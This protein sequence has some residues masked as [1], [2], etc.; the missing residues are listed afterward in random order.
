MIAIN[1]K[2]NM[3]PNWSVVVTII[4]AFLAAGVFQV[5]TNASHAERLRNLENLSVERSARLLRIEQ[6]LDKA[7]EML[8]MRVSDG[9]KK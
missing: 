1:T 2:R 9:A 4:L 3:T 5:T 8:Y 6:K 7:L